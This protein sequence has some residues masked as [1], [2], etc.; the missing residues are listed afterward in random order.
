MKIRRKI[1]FALVLLSVHVGDLWSAELTSPQLPPTSLHDTAFWLA[2]KNLRY[3]QAWT[4]PGQSSAWSM[5]CSNATRWLHQQVYGIQLPR[6]ASAQ[7]EFFRERGEFR[8]ARPDA[9]KLRQILRPGDLL[10]W[11]HTYR[12]KRKPPVTHVMTYLGRDSA[13]RM[14]MVGAQGSRGLD[15]YR[16]DPEVSLGGYR[17]FLW[18]RRESRFIGYARPRPYPS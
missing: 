2:G 12:P 11:E 1:A 14:L 13:G 15:I 9:E 10:F 3:N 6:T 16:F 5:D 17:W 4:P 7:Y 18:F 8:R